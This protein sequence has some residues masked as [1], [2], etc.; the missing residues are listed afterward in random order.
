MSINKISRPKM[1]VILPRERLFNLLDRGLERPV[2]WIEG[3]GG[4]GKSTLVASFLDHRE[5]QSIWYQVGEGDADPATFFYNLGLEAQQHAPRSK[6]QL[7]FLSMEYLSS[8]PTFSRRYFTQLYRMVAP[9][10]VIVLDNFQ[11]VPAT[12]PLHDLIRIGFEAVPDGVTFLIVSRDEAPPP[13]ARL[14]ANGAMGIVDWQEMRFDL[15]EAR[16]FVTVRYGTP[17]PEGTVARLHEKTEGWAAGLVLLLEHVRREQSNLDFLDRFT[18]AM[19]TNYFASEVF[20]QLDVH[21][22]DFLLRTSFLPRIT[23]PQAEALTGSLHCRQ[24]LTTLSNNNYFTT[25]YEGAVAGYQYHQLFQDFLRNRANEH[26]APMELRAVKKKAADIL[27]EAGFTAD[28]GKI[29]AEL[30]EWDCLA[31]MALQQAQAI[32]AQGRTALLGEW[33]A[34]LPSEVRDRKPWTLFWLGVCGLSAGPQE[35]RALLEKAFA[36]FRATGDRTGLFFSWCGVVETAIHVSEYVT[37]HQWIEVLHDVLS[38][39]PQFPSR[40]TEMRVSLCLFNA[41]AFGL[42]N[43]PHI[44]AMRERAFTL[45]C[46]ETIADT[47]LFLSSGVHLIVHFIYQGDFT[48]AR[49]ILDLLRGAAGSKNATDLVKIMVNTIEAHYAFATCDLDICSTKAFEALALAAESEIRI[50]D[51]HNY[52]HALAAALAKGDEKLIAELIPKMSAGLVGARSVDKAYFHWLMAWHCSLRGEF[53]PASQHLEL[54]LKLAKEIG[55]LAPGTAML[56]NKAE[57][58]LEL[59]NEAGAAECLEKVHTTVMSMNSAYLYFCYLITDANLHLN[60]GDEAQG[61]ESLR[62]AFALGRESRI[63]N[64]YFWRPALMTRLCLKALAAGIEEDYVRELIVRRRLVPDDPP[65]HLENFPWMLRINALGYFTIIRNGKPLLFT[66]KVQ[67]KPLELLKALVTMG[68]EEKTEGEIA[69]LL[70]PEADGDM[71][72]HNLKITLHRLRE[73]LGDSGAIQ[74]REG[75]LA[76]DPRTV[77]TD[78]RAFDRLLALAQAEGEKGNEEV[79]V[80]LTE[81]ALD[82]YRGQFLPGDI[83]RP[84]AVSLRNR[85]KSKFILNVVA[86]ATLR[87]RGGDYRNA[88][89][90]CL[91]GLEIDDLAEELYQNLMICYH[92]AGLGAE[93]AATYQRCRLTLAAQG[94]KPSEKT[95][96]LYRTLVGD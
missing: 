52:G 21:T 28:A 58:Y 45:I 59:G 1:S 24:I 40:E 88:I 38:E 56:I 79:A 84:W 32:M 18:P 85:L 53:A 19:I 33:L 2:T 71:G 46:T 12:S 10:C 30:E 77:W 67:K 73:I 63:E 83:D 91:R 41:A 60:R 74:V 81:K 75:R 42:P 78:I 7:P 86:L 57:I 43:H 3:P 6:E 34:V 29:Y 23:I 93:A 62:A 4:S 54:A 95:Q 15:D 94:Y 49:L 36:I 16:E 11:H 80:R 26:F 51:T 44:E 47:N 64:F 35:S 50:W 76:L 27:K 17:L 39:N 22:R 8:L 70:W 55:F 37:M 87:Q 14:L 61:V 13:Y 96:A 31:D 48:R 89:G 90:I 82:L 65:H 69:E 20:D 72:R 66:G 92:A 25:R 9:H 5:L 68:G